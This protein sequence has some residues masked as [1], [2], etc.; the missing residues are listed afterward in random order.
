[1]PRMSGLLPTLSALSTP[2]RFEVAQDMLG[3]VG[4]VESASGSSLATSP[5]SPCPKPRRV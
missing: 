3:A 4:R 2:V 1:M 5:E